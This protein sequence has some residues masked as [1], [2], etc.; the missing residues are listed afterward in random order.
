MTIT[1][2]LKFIDLFAGIGGFRLAFEKLG[3]D[4]VFASEWEINEDQLL[5]IALEGGRIVTS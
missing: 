5:E 1:N 4:C 3:C 2:S